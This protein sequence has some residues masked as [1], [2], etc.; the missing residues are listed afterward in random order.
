METIEIVAMLSVAK[1]IAQEAA[2][3][4][5]CPLSLSL[6]KDV[7]KVTD[8]VS[9]ITKSVRLKMKAELKREEELKRRCP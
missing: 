6:L 3:H 7:Q 4:G 5:A 1:D 8:A 9:I 2:Q